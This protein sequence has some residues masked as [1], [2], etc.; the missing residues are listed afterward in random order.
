MI[1]LI[2][3]RCIE[4]DDQLSLRGEK[5]KES[6]RKDKEEGLLPFFVSF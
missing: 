4:T 2:K 5:L 1:G 3:M 6:I